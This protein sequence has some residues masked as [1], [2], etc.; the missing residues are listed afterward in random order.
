MLKYFFHFLG[1]GS[2]YEHPTG[3]DFPSVKAAISHAKDVAAELGVD[4]VQYQGQCVLVTDSI[5]NEVARAAVGK[6][7]PSA[8]R[9]KSPR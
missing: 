7:A 5:G 8:N 9:A 3:R 1:K 2:V 6:G 4:E